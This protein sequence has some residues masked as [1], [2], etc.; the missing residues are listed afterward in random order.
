MQPEEYFE[1]FYDKKVINFITSMF[2]LYASQDKGDD[3]FSTNAEEIKCWLGILML[4]GY[5]SFPRWRMMW[6]YHSELYLLSVSNVMRR[7]RFEILK[8]YAHFSVNTK[9]TKDKFTGVSC[10]SRHAY[11]ESHSLDCQRCTEKTS[12]STFHG[13]PVQPFCEWCRPH[14]PKHR[15]LQNGS[16]IKKVV[17]ACFAFTVDASLHNAWQLYKKGDNNNPLDYLGFAR[18]IMQFYL[19]KYGTPPAI[20]SNSAATKP[21]KKRVLPGIRFDSANQ[22]LL[23]AEKQ[24]TCALCKKN[25]RKMCKKCRVDIHE[26]CFEKFLTMEHQ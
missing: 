23:P 17:V 8:A 13:V 19:Q 6:E 16:P 5:M 22:S 21:L 24:S 9:L 1:L 4:L 26:L 7:N 2:N 14:G 18:R 20:P 12:G 15:Q 11:R 25:S 10:S 3:L